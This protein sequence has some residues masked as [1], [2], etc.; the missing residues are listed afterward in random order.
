MCTQCIS[1]SVPFQ[2]D[3]DLSLCESDSLGDL[4][5]E[6]LD[7]EEMPGCSS[8]F[9]VLVID[10]GLYSNCSLPTGFPQAAP[11]DPFGAQR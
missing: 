8:L 11:Q 9:K 2:E 5:D 7:D 3:D 1:S 6:D 10:Y 4:S